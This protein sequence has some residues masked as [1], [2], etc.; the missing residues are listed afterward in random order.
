MNLTMINVT[1]NYLTLTPSSIDLPLAPF[2]SY[3]PPPHHPSDLPHF[4]PSLPHFHILPYVPYVA[5]RS[6]DPLSIG[7]TGRPLKCKG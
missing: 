4:P 6:T 1:T 7:L 2:E 3:S 5:Y